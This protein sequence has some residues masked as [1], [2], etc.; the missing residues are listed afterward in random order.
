MLRYFNP[1]TPNAC[2]LGITRV[3][4]ASCKP[5]TTPLVGRAPL[6]GTA[7]A[8]QAGA[9]RALEIYRDEIDRLLAL[10][11]CPGIAVLGRDYL[12]PEDNFQMEKALD[13]L[14]L[15]NG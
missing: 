5:R 4:P 7:V 13:S 15:V 10:I 2:G 3:K 8:G 9:V 14:R 6:Y 12:A 11:G 1:T